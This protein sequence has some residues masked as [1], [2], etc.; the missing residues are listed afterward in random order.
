MCIEIKNMYLATP[1]DHFEFMKIPIE[2]IP[3]E[4]IQAYNLQPMI[5]KGYIY[6]Q[7]LS[8]KMVTIFY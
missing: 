6:M 5:K 8:L 3:D 1:M 7:I 4:F 2:L